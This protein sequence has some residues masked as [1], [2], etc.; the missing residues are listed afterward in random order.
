MIACMVGAG[1]EIGK[2][3]AAERTAEIMC[4]ARRLTRTD[5]NAI[6]LLPLHKCLSLTELAR[7]LAQAVAA[8][9]ERVAVLSPE[10]RAPT[11]P[12]HTPPL[13]H[14]PSGAWTEVYLPGP[15]SARP[16]LDLEFATE[17][18]RPRYQRVIVDTGFAPP[19]EQASLLAL[20][21]GVLLAARPGGA[22]EFRLALLARRLKP[23]QRLGVLLLD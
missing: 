13:V 3:L 11:A 19:A 1:G 8:L 18:L 6:G 14:V 7:S 10:W 12:P 22:S 9:G 23:Q 5:H 16:C 2:D 15:P 4:L 21:D 20:L 17:W